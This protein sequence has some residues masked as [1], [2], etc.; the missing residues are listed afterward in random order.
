M[1]KKVILIAGYYGLEL[2]GDEAILEAMLHDLTALDP[3]VSYIVT[4]QAPESTQA[5]YS[6]R[7]IELCNLKAVT[8][9]IEECDLVIVG[10]GGVFNE[11]TP[12]RGDGLL[13]LR[14]EFNV[15]CASLPL[16]CAA[17]EKPCMIYA[18][19]VEPLRSADARE[20]VA[21][22]F[23]LA[24]V[25]TV[26]DQGSLSILASTGAPTEKV[27]VTAD[28][29]FDLPSTQCVPDDMLARL[30][31]EAIRP[32]LGV[33]L[34]HWWPSPDGLSIDSTPAPWEAEVA[35]ALDEFLETH[36]GTLIFIP[37]Q[38]Q[39]QWSYSDDIPVF[40]R[41][42]GM[43]RCESKGHMLRGP[44]RPIEVSQVLASCDLVLGMRFHSVVLSIKNCTPCVAICYSLKVKTAMGRSGLDKF[45]LRLEGLTADQLTKALEEC[46]VNRGQIKDSLRI[47]SEE[48]KLLA[49]E[50]AR[51]AL[52]LLH[53]HEGRP[54][55]AS[56]FHQM[57][58]GLIRR[59]TKLL[60]EKEVELERMNRL[61]DAVRQVTREAIYER[62]QFGVAE[63][64]LRVLLGMQADSPEWH[65]L[66]AFCLQMQDK[67]TDEAF[68]H[69]R[70]ALTGGFNEFWVRY[71]RGALHLKMGNTEEARADL[72]RA[73]EL[74]PE[75]VGA[76]DLLHEL[77]RSNV[78]AQPLRG[79]S[80]GPHTH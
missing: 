72:K 45:A 58:P 59:Q 67:S 66:L 5:T 33:Q 9:V 51:L 15:F 34:R 75:H 57:A 69:Y 68:S 36:G 10:G 76:R 23:A 24:T 78:G 70:S 32:I 80:D 7:A 37:F 52:D 46:Y 3:D 49:F 65:Y 28:P 4:S 30:C 48:M 40:Q 31:V 50:N 6:V 61:Q 63:D 79:S 1:R 73:C 54:V 14:Q 12:W 60:M 38:Q 21:N 2:I 74:N 8:D 35:K 13:T 29:A 55:V 27:R 44:L 42:T 64:L 53:E 71:N 26:R 56:A 20:Q 25:A 17:Y 18:V 77:S 19:G 22:A 47:V 62:Q 41:V 16:I 43:M 39:S 11:Y